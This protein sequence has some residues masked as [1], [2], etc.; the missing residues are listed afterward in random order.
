[1]G[2]EIAGIGLGAAFIAGLL[3]FLAPCTLPLVPGYLG[4]ISGV[5]GREFDNPAEAKV[6]RR[7]V[8]INGTSF[9][10]GFSIIFILVGTVF[11]ALGGL[12]GG[13]QTILTRVG[14]VIVI[15][16]GLFM[17]GVFQIGFLQRTGGM[18]I[19]KFLEV[20]KPTSS[21][22][23]GGAFALGWTPCVGPV[24]ASILLLASDGGSAFQGALLLA[25]FSAGLAVPFLLIS[26]AFAQATEKINNFYAFVKK[27][28]AIILALFG[29]ILGF[30]VSLV[31]LALAQLVGFN[32]FPLQSFLID[33]HPFVVPI[34]TALVLAFVGQKKADIDTLSVIG[35]LFLVSL[36]FLLLLDAFALLVQFGF[37]FLELFGLSGFEETLYKFL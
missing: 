7:K 35:G 15:V 6:A 3:M 8:V 2:L 9:I 22:A 17:L 14:G 26:L 13:F 29:F 25:V 24:L 19:P 18:K 32:T 33:N 27:Y 11:G 12:L 30:V 34:I 37:R 5:S 31:L 10:L 20:G 36:G 4:F 1:M 16:F 28:R 21:V 23:I